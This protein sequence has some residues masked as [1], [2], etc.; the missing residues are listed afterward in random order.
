MLPVQLLAVHFKLAHGSFPPRAG[1]QRLCVSCLLGASA[2]VCALWSPLVHAGPPCV[3]SPS[4]Y[5]NIASY[6]VTRQGLET[7][8]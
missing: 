8:T 5:T 1:E 7:V 3:P 4:S 6:L 2:A